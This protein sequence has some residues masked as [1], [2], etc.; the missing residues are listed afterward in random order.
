MVEAEI[1]LIN[2][3]AIRVQLQIYD[4]RTLA[5]TCVTGPGEI[6]VLPTA[7]ERYD[8]YLKNSVTGWEVAHKLNSAAKTLTLTQEN[9]RFVVT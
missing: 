2:R 8:I 9:G 1:T 3:A 7:L 5:G 6:G 4:G